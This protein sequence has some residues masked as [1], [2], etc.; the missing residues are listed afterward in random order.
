MQL[1]RENLFLYHPPHFQPCLT[2]HTFKLNI[3][4][5]QQLFQKILVY[6]KD[7]VTH[8]D[9]TEKAEIFIVVYTGRRLAG[10]SKRT[11]VP[12]IQ[13]TENGVLNPHLPSGIFHPYQLDESISNFKGVWCTFSFL[14]YF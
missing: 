14:F 12:F 8:A 13:V 10:K 2:M 4:I 3:M 11:D 5:S 1:K 7:G 6:Q 9:A